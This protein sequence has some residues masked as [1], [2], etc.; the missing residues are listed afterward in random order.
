MQ[1][2]AKKAI[3]GCILNTFSTKTTTLCQK[4]E[5]KLKCLRKFQW[6]GGKTQLQSKKR[7]IKLL[8]GDQVFCTDIE[9]TDTSWVSDRT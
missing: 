4:K 3:D 6:Q 2:H 9:N 7:E 1:K 8:R 5:S